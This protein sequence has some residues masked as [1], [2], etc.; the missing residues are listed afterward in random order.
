MMR[1]AILPVLLAAV[2]LA[3]A[4][5]A[6]AAEWRSEQPVGEG[7]FLSN[8]GEIGDI[9]CWNGEAN[10]CLLI[11]AGNKGVAAGIFAYDGSGWYRYSTVCGGHEGH[12]AWVGPD[13]FW[14]VSDQQAG[15]QIEGVAASAFYA[16]SLC[17]FKDGRVVAS[18][19]E[20]IG[21]AGAYMHMNAAACAGPSDCWFAGER[22]PG[23]INEGAFHLHWSGSSMTASPSLGEQQSGLLDPGRAVT[24][25]AYLQ[26]SLYEGVQVREGDDP[27]STESLEPSFLHRVEPA[28]ANPFQ[29]LFPAAPIAYGEAGVEASELGGFRLS[30]DGGLLWAV[31]GAA[32]SLATVTVLQLGAEGLTQLPLEDPEGV[33]EAGDSVSSVAAE[34]GRN[35]VWIGFMRRGDFKRASTPARLTPIYG[36]GA[37][38]PGV[39]LPAEGEGIERTG[40]AGPIAC[41][42]AEQC[43]MATE[44]G[45]LFHLG[46]DPAP[47]ADPEMHGPVITVRPPD[48]SVPVVSPVSLPED[49]SGADGERKTSEQEEVPSQLEELPHRRPA[50]VSA[51][52]Q[53]LLHGTIL[54]LSFLLRVKAHVQLL[55]KRGGSVVAK[56]KRYTMAKGHRSLRLTLDP[57]RWPTK[58]DLQAHALKEGSK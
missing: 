38:D 4:A 51:V 28:V 33:L 8:L 20:P 10:R 1:R 18:Y 55:A 53:R 24:G 7:G 2:L 32:G 26:G 14:T 27:I 31:S 36:D 47:N 56:T 40:P 13:E 6:G 12:L 34:P 23:D 17:H 48:D 25:L 35:D 41:P 11:T 22:L 57:E 19:G 42:A 45:W 39:V 21:A 16:I 50:L 37:V 3:G 29:P 54:E 49:N 58:L 46:P 44:R 15:Q 5:P 43:W 52:K 30:V 9:E